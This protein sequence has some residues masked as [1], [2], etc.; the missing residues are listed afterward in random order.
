MNWQMFVWGL[1]VFFVISLPT[2]SGLSR[3]LSALKFLESTESR[4]YNPLG[5]IKP[6]GF[7]YALTFSFKITFL[8]AVILDYV[9][10]VKQVYYI[11]SLFLFFLM[12]DFI[13]QFSGK[14]LLQL[15]LNVKSAFAGATVPVVGI[16]L[17]NFLVQRKLRK[18]LP[19]EAENYRKGKPSPALKTFDQR[20]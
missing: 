16:F 6:G 9:E 5:A 19:R 18:L 12:I 2:I 17:L 8:T 14:A 7:A 20:G 1:I 11:V 10:Y 13:V 4:A 3:I 15:S